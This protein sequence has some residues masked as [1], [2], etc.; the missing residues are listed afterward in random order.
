M[1]LDEELK[2]IGIELNKLT[3]QYARVRI[4]TDLARPGID[5]VYLHHNRRRQEIPTTRKND[6]LSSSPVPPIADLMLLD[7]VEATEEADKR[8]HYDSHRHADE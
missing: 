1:P 3:V 6:N 4:D 5:A 8:E 2:A 7:M